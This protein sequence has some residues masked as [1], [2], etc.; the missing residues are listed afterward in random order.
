M[1]VELVEP[2]FMHLDHRSRCSLA[3]VCRSTYWA[4]QKII[5]RCNV[6][7]GDFHGAEYG[8]PRCA[9]FAKPGTITRFSIATLEGDPT[10]P[11][12]GYMA[13]E[14]SMVQRAMLACINMGAVLQRLDLVRV[15]LLTLGF[16]RAVAPSLKI[17]RYLGKWHVLHLRLGSLTNSLTA[18]VN[19]DLIEV[20]DGPGLL[21]SVTACAEVV[22]VDFWPSEASLRVADVDV[23]KALP[24]ILAKILP[25][26]LSQGAKILLK[27]GHLRRWLR[28]V[29]PAID[30]D[31][32]LALEMKDTD[33]V[34][35]HH[36][37]YMDR[38]G[39]LQYVD[40]ALNDGSQVRCSR[41]GESLAAC[42]FPADEIRTYAERPVC[43]ACVHDGYLRW[44]RRGGQA[45]AIDQARSVECLMRPERCLP[46][47]L[48]LATHNCSFQIE[49]DR[50]WNEAWTERAARKARAQSFLE[51]SNTAQHKERSKL[52]GRQQYV[53][54]MYATIGWSPGIRTQGFW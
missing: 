19:C 21:Q 18:V 4:A 51:R 53:P 31:F 12:H 28:R 15:P 46:D 1:P 37:Q 11:G 29:A 25:M 33:K 45:I 24:A 14:Q 16:L 6:S 3:V 17:L 22:Q 10:A 50:T 44:A 41:H 49:R 27:H 38:C 35:E 9:M 23:D 36:R 34:M 42:F 43:W 7:L 40:D 30:D 54:I 26:S 5:R 52:K 2:I 8:A 20:M 13:W 47:A 39:A 32:L 48:R